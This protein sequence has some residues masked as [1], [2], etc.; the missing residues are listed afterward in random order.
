MATVNTLNKKYGNH[1]VVMLA[2]QAVAN[3]K[4]SRFRLPMFEAG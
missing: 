1:A 4:K 3:I 2:G